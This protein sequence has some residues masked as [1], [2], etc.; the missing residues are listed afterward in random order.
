MAP[1]KKAEGKSKDTGGAKGGK[2]KDDAK[3][4]GAQRIVVRHILCEKQSKKDEALAE[5]NKNPTLDNFIAVAKVYSEDKPRQGGALGTKQKGELHAEFEKVA[6]AL[7]ES[8][9]SN[10][11]M[12]E[13]KTDFG[14]HIIVVEGR[15]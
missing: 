1:K 9:G 3:V 10:L 13:A 6:F 11:N 2:G 15:K 4:K 8:K 5:I 14:Y 12:G 7:P